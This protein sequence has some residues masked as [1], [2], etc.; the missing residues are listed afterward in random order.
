MHGKTN[1][2]DSGFKKRLL[3]NSVLFERIL[4]EL[5]LKLRKLIVFAGVSKMYELC[6]A[7]TV[8]VEFRDCLT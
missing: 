5:L 8:P 3:G 7:T 1:S 6:P 2:P 4:N